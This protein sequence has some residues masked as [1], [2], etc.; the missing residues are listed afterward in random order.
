MLGDNTGLVPDETNIRA[1]AIE[2]PI[3]HAAIEENLY[4]DAG[5][6]AR[7]QTEADNV[8]GDVEEFVEST[9]PSS[10]AEAEA[11][12]SEWK[13]P[14]DPLEEVPDFVSEKDEV[15]DP[16]PMVPVFDAGSEMEAQLIIGILSASGIP[17]MLDNFASR[18]WGESIGVAQASWG[19]VLV[20]QEHAAQARAAIE[21]A[22][23]AGAQSQTDV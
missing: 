16:G 10:L 15:L 20:A 13:V 18:A 8:L 7:R 6:D 19:H 4:P 9:D 11:E 12:L 21:S 17:S 5:E 2:T 22:K 1:G 14:E 3:M 23:E